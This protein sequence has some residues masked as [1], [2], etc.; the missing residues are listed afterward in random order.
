MADTRIGGQTPNIP[1]PTTTNTTETTSEV[2]PSSIGERQTSTDR[3]E[4]ANTALAQKMQAAENK[5]QHNLSGQLMRHSLNQALPT[6]SAPPTQAGGS[7]HPGTLDMQH[8]LN[9]WRA[10]NNLKPI[11]ED[12]LDSEDT[13]NAI[14]EFQRQN[15][16]KESGVPTPETLKSLATQ[17]DIIALKNNPSTAAHINKLVNSEG[18]KKLPP[19]V[20]SD[21]I[22]RFKQYAA[23]GEL[24][25]I[26][27]M[28]N[29][30]DQL[31]F[32]NL[33]LSSRKL[34]LDTMAARPDD[35][36]LATN[37]S[38]MA[39]SPFAK[40]DET[41]QNWA[42]NKIKS[43]GGDRNKIVSLLV[44]TS[45]TTDPPPGRPHLPGKNEMLTRLMNYP[46][47]TDQVENMVKILGASGFSDLSVDVQNQILDGLP[48]RFTSGQLSYGEAANIMI[49]A[50]SPQFE[51]LH[52]D[53]RD[54]MM[55]TLAMRPWNFKLANALRE[56]AENGRF[57]VDKRTWRQTLER[58]DADTPD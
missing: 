45:R 10:E 40:L 52:P 15:G 50:T 30:I 24:R 34:M 5:G 39:G 12:G 25:N 3:Q 41:S 48:S 8:S 36:R 43:Y 28:V 14:R 19:D 56:L 44:I 1:S 6:G 26:G 42:L 7:A 4:P 38:R 54:E 51:K 18:F 22:N 13:R 17:V 32:A 57:Q 9:K 23:A 33:P 21:V 2:S 20:Q 47:D 11:K 31:G 55:N 58:V 46:P 29:V 37:L 53:K 27:N 16:I 49:L 35:D